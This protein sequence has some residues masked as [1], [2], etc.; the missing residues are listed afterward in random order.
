[1]TVTGANIGANTFVTAVSGNA[2]SG[3]T[4]TLQY[5]PG[6]Y[7]TPN[8]GVLGD[9]SARSTLTFGVPAINTNFLSTTGTGP[10]TYNYEFG[11]SKQIE[12]SN[13]GITVA[14]AAV[15]GANDYLPDSENILQYFPSTAGGLTG[16]VTGG[17]TGVG[18]GSPNAFGYVTPSDA[19]SVYIAPNIT[20]D[21]SEI[22]Y[23]NKTP[24][25]GLAD[26]ESLVNQL[27]ANSETPII[28]WPW[29]DYGITDWPIG[30]IGTTPPGYTEALFQ[31][32]IAY[33]Y[34]AG[35]EFVT[36]EDLASRI[37]A[38]QAATLSETTSGSV[39]TATVTPNPSEPDLGAMAVNV[40]NG[41]AGQVIENAG[42]WYA[43]DSDSVFLPYGGGTFT[44]TLGTTQDDV[45][46]VDYLPMRADLQSGLTGNGTNLT[47]SF[48][49]DGT[50][51]AHV[52]TPGTNTVSIQLSAVGTGAGPVYATLVGDDL[53]LVFDDGALGISADSPQGVAVLHNV[54]IMESPTAV[55]GASIVFDGPTVAI[56][57]PAGQTT[58]AS[59]TISGT[60]TESVASETVGTT[61]TLYDNGSTT[62]LGT[63]TV[64]A[65][66]TWS[67]TVT[68]S[69]GA[70]SIVAKDTDLANMTG[71]SSAAVF[72][73]GTPPVAPTLS[74]ASVVNGYVNAANDT[75]GQTLGGT[76]ADGSTVNVYLNG[77]TTPAF[78]TPANATT[79]AWS[80]TL[81]ALANGLYN[82][83]ATATA[84]GITSALSSP[85]AFTVDTTVPS[86]PTLSDASVVNGYVNAAND[87]AAQTLGGIA[88][89]GSTVNVYL[90]GSPA[91]A[92]TTPADAVTGAWSVTLGALANGSYSYTATA[93]DVA[94]NISVASA[95][96]SFSVDTVVPSVPT[97]SDASVVGGYVNLANDTAAQTLGGTAEAG[98]TVNVYQKGS[99]MPA[100]TTAANATTGAWSV[101]LGVLASGPYSYT[102]TATDVA[103]NTSAA[104]A[105]Y[106]FTVDAAVPSPPTLLDASVV[107]G[108]VNAANDT[109]GQTLG[110]T[111]EDGST[112]NVY[113]NGSTM[114]AFTTA[115]NST[116]GAWSVTLGAL[117]NG[118]YNYTATATDVAGNTS[119]ASPAYS[120]TVNTVVP[121]APTLSDASVVGGVV[122]TAGDTATQA[123]GG[124]AEAGSTV[125]V[126]LNG[127]PTPMFTTTAN[128]A[129]GAWSVTLGVLANGSYSYMA[130]ATDAA[131]NT[132]AASAAY[133]FTVTTTAP[134]QPTIT[135]A[136]TYV[137][138]GSTGHWNLAGSAAGGSTVTVSDGATKLGTTTAN[139]TTGAWTFTTAENNTAIRDY[140]VTATN[141]LGNTS[142]PSA[143][144]YEGTP[145]ADTFSFASEAALLA[146]ALINGGL[147]TN[148]I[149][150]TS[151]AILTDA[152]F[153]HIQSIQIVGLTGASS[154]TLGPNASAGGLGTVVTGNGATNVTDSNSGTLTINAAA[155]GAGN[156]LTL[157][158][159]TADTVTNLTGNLA[160]GSDTGALTVTA[161]GTAAQTVATGSA[162]TSIADSAAGGGVTVDA[163]ALGTN[164][165]TLTGSAAGTVNNLAGNV[166]ATGLSGAL[167]VT[168]T[169]SGTHSLSVTT[170]TGN[171]SITDNEALGSVNVNANATA[172]GHTLTL[173]G[174]AAETVTTL[175]ENIVATALTGSLTVTTKTNALSI[176]TGMGAT[177]I[178]DALETGALTLTGA[179]ATTV[180]K[181]GG[182][183]TAT[184][185]SGALTVT[186]TGG[187]QTVT[188]GSGNI[189]ITDGSTGVLTVNGAA[190]AGTLT[191]TGAGAVTVTNLKGNL[192]AT[193]DSGTL[194][195]SATGT[196]AQTV[197]TGSGAMSIADSATG[198][199][200]TVDATKFGTNT[201]TLTGSAAKTVNN[202]AG[203]VV[204]TGSG[205]L[206]VS[207]TGPGAQSVTTGNA[208]TSITDNSSGSMMVNNVNA[209][210]SGHTLTLSGSA[211]E[212]V[213]NLAENIVAT[214]L[215]GALTVTTQTNA[216]SIATGTGANTIN[217]GAETG[218][219]TLKGANA[220]T[221]T[222]LGGN[223]TAAGDSG[224]LTV[225][226]TGGTQTVATGSGNISIADQSTGVL[227]VNGAA[228]AGSTLTLTGTGAVTVNNL[229]GNLNATGDSG[230]LTVTATGTAA[231]TVTTG[232]GAMSI[233]D[234]AAGGSVTVNATALGT[235]TL[236]LTGAAAKTVNNL[237]GNVVASGAG[238]LNVTTG[239][240]AALSIAAN[241][242]GSNTVNA[243]AMTSGDTLTLTGSRAATVS[244]GGN[245]SAGTDTGALTVT[246]T[247][248]GPQTIQTG[249][250]KDTITAL[251][252]ADTIEAGGGGDSIN[253]SGHTA[254]DSFIYALT[255][256]SLNTVAGHDTITGFAANDLLD[257]SQ[258]NTGLSIE[259]QVSSG[260]TV[261]ADSIAWLYSMGNAM[262]Y[263]NDTASALATGN[264]SLMEITLQG[265]SS[266]LSAS[267][268][269]A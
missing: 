201:L 225:T 20:F 63:A 21:F 159:S 18:S 104:S 93:T 167:T 263:V 188:T 54:T 180:T 127:T 90:N 207:A 14:G 146:A 199:S 105:A 213:T 236:T 216:L 250:G 237:I 154:V 131:G 164:T 50:V 80:V 235:N 65:G 11:Q 254:L 8:L 30:G 224:A 204:A 262:L 175:A 128:A 173:S 108:Y 115:A 222:K 43:Y 200:V 124:T 34:N 5:E 171:T 259:G 246:A 189:S 261:A 47:F 230:A 233:A 170:G 148:T 117:A 241:G 242:T 138:S 41:A 210:G 1:M 81:G 87:T 44:V 137:G 97:L 144:D 249:S 217:A 256:D 219:L 36:S 133:S 177:T 220:A 74:D 165:L 52:K 26:W 268:F 143:A 214:A 123:L 206:T 194:T 16:Y 211:A 83:T 196:A 264:A 179:G 182:N 9:I 103:G 132:S 192:V 39:I 253:V 99:A 75:A 184:G 265:V 258:L 226:T 113:L 240:T 112:V 266:G 176:A 79:G 38:E 98:S 12:D 228:L 208:N 60:A 218:A 153:A 125:N 197:A 178:N 55:G 190:L 32:F 122:N 68:L 193:G 106:S 223:L 156:V 7:N 76:A 111:A 58:T 267:H 96:Y 19:G 61:V 22:E 107:N 269:H 234:N 238:A 102:A 15:P 25:S 35:Y 51:D 3:Y 100:F 119:A 10:F 174:S 255:S 110:G 121:S 227:T 116:N 92:F 95:A 252:G 94:G 46:H 232:S 251:L 85:Y 205:A 71:A 181:L 198:G 135:P 149:Q 73:L 13:I 172:A 151:P 185:D 248:K 49:G 215:T 130:T 244:V 209:T 239:A 48:T 70:N 27:S 37:A 134:A 187:T 221:V 191:L 257:F 169:S 186:T 28:V 202:L 212:T 260:S 158:G 140:T 64:Q 4:L 66:G 67:T 166:V 31:D 139:A 142:V 183:L 77:S 42:S 82:Y 157:A 243:G 89:A 33:A 88:E 84:G 59:Q 23:E 150:L 29:H 126:Y 114:P 162:N 91:A 129:T 2:T 45:T 118:P 101:T 24:D 69:Q 17:W 229:N 168:A 247:G 56:T 245:L 203:N 120:F 136:P 53:S 145:G 161:T 155:L 57:T 141:A 86:A 72:T 152:D 109:T 160:V 40:V 163:T 62:A 147:G 6:G 231:Q 195:V 78:T